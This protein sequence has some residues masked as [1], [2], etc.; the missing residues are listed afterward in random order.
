MKRTEE[1]VTRKKCQI[2]LAMEQGRHNGWALD[3]LGDLL[4]R[5][6][7]YGVNIHLSDAQENKLME[8]L[9]PDYLNDK[10]S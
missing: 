6:D 8:L 1:W 9:D 2:T 7:K 10:L 3:F 5:L 4:K